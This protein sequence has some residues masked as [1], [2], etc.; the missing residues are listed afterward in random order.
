MSK[1]EFKQFI[2][3]IGFESNYGNRFEY[4]KFILYLN[5]NYYIFYN[6][7]EWS[8]DINLN[9]LTLFNTITRSIK[10]KQLLG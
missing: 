4:K 3:S 10:L 1:E 7:S 8:Y 6:G 2:E 9:D 5:S